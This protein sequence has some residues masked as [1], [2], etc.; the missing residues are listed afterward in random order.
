MDFGDNSGTNVAN[1]NPQQEEV[2]NL[3]TGKI[4]VNPSGE[5]AEDIN[6]GDADNAGNEQTPPPVKE[7]KDKTSNDSD[8]DSLEPGTEIE[9]DGNK[10][11]VD[12]NGNLLN[13][14]GSI[15]K[16][17]KDVKE[18]MSSFEKVDET[19][20]KDELSIKSIQDAIGIDIVDDN[21][22]PIEFDNTPEG[23]KA[24]LNAVVE[25]SKQEIAD[26]TINSLVA[27][28]PFIQDV[29]NYYITNNN[30]LEGY[31]QSV[32]RSNIEIDE[33]NV[34]QQKVII[35]T[36]WKEQGRKGD[37]EAYI[38]YLEST[39]VL[40]ATAQ[41][42]L[43]GLKE[44]DE[45]KRKELAKAAEEKQKKDLE[46]SIAYWN[47]IKDVIENR[48]IGR[49]T[50]PESIIIERDGKKLS[51]TPTDFFNYLY[52]VDDKGYS[53]YQY[54]LAEE[55]PE[56]RRDD[57]ILRAYLKFVGGDYSNLVDMAINEKE[58]Q[59]LRLKAKENHKSQMRITKPTN[60]PAKGGK[61][62]F[63]N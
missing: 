35:R 55:T 36:A 7:T 26:A 24:Y 46:S 53:R 6:D 48:K 38:K 18:W 43:D 23:V 63:G 8:K 58:V 22:K 27:K 44:S 33:N 42:E 12:E 40:F 39:G 21:D 57:A 45:E 49:Y 61:I 60:T 16:E 52:Q 50:I 34:E 54:D 31:N 17:A 13:E 20:E 47:G 4:E 56:S 19:E 5:P 2:T 11:T 9:V 14:D 59:K 1:N 30:S 28:Y 15:F 41:E 37:V 62:D 10:Y 3:Q 51:V 25:T 29:I 32:D